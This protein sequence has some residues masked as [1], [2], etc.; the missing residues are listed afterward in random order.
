MSGISGHRWP[1]PRGP[2]LVP[3]RRQKYLYYM[4][5]SIIYH[6]A[7]RSAQ[8]GLD[9]TS[10]SHCWVLL[11]I[12][13]TAQLA[14]LGH[15]RLGKGY[16]RR[17]LYCNMPLINHQKPTRGPHRRSTG[18]C[19]WWVSDLASDGPPLALRSLLAGSLLD[20]DDKCQNS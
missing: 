2:N 14:H 5:T 7:E 8:R 10:T 20:F 15:P 4:G 19:L 12:S 6:I 3:I 17:G 18:G 9:L 13:V 1:K 16:S 11:Y